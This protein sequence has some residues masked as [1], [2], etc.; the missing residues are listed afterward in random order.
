MGQRHA[1]K[2][3][4]EA[5]IVLQRRRA[6]YFVNDRRVANRNA[7]RLPRMRKLRQPDHVTNLP[8][9]IA[10]HKRPREEHS[11]E[12]VPRVQLQIE[13]QCWLVILR[14]RPSDQQTIPTRDQHLC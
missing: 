9:L 3:K 4:S 10:Q 8:Q 11:H 13:D 2:K 6:T 7:T 5:T 12:H 1:A 14:V